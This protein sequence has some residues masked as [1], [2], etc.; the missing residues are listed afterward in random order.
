MADV[1]AARRELEAAL[2]PEAVLADPLARRLYARDASMVEGGCAF[3]ALPTTTEQVRRACGGRRARPPV[4]PRGSG[5]GLA[6]AATPIG[7]SLVRRRPRS[8][9]GIIEIRPE[10]PP[11]V[12]RARG[13]STSTS[14]TR[15]ARSGSPTPPTPRASRSRSI[16][17]NVNTNAGGPH[18]LA[19]G[20]TSAH[21]LAL[22]VVIAD[23]SLERLGA[24]A[25]EAAGYDLRGVVVG[26]RG[27]A[28]RRGRAC[29]RLVPIPPA[30]RT[31]LLDSTT[32]KPAPPP[33]RRSSRDGV[34][35]AAVEMMDQGI[36][37][38]V[39]AFAHAGL[40]GR[41]R[42]GAARRGRRHARRP[43]TAQTR[44][45]EAAAAANGV[46]ERPRGRRRSRTGPAVEGPQVGVRR[47]RA[48]RP[49]LP[50][51]RLRRARA[52]SWSR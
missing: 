47:D 11:G 3:V 5:T 24:E 15:C 29:V 8:M 22:D 38:A 34:V 4:V 10:R 1:D 17:G 6:G 25:P 19:Y 26:Q 20:V 33:S 39:E 42:R 35:P 9:T 16:G 50:P 51:A 14:R 31:M 37:R 7:D 32:S 36:V 44:E 46:V 21:V 52:P 30:V 18:C 43:S 2:G 40:S 27:H 28:R 13:A 12:G 49:P 48:D 41:C 23:G 45:V